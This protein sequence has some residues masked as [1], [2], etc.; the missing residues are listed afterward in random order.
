MQRTSTLAAYLAWILALVAILMP[1]TLASAGAGILIEARDA[2]FA[3]VEEP[4]ARFEHGALTVAD[5]AVDS[6]GWAA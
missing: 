6:R 4:P 5:I 1:P 2:L 3:L